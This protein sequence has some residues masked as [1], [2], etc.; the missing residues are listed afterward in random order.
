MRGV[1]RSKWA[2]GVNI[3]SKRVVLILL[4]IL[5]AGNAVWSL[6]SGRTAPWVAVVAYTLVTLAVLLWDDYRAG[7][8]VGIAGFVIHAIELVAGGATDLRPLERAW[9]FANIFLPGLLVWSNWVLLRRVR[10]SP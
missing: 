3:A 7:L 1:I 10:R 2:R 4:V 8:I 5:A 6:A 9:L